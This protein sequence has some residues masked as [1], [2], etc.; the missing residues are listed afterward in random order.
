M[1]S[2]YDDREDD[3]LFALTE[4]PTQTD[5]FIQPKTLN[6]LSVHKR[7]EVFNNDQF[8]SCSLSFLER[9]MKIKEVG[10]G[11]DWHACLFG[12]L[13][14]RETD[15]LSFHFVC[16]VFWIGFSEP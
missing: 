3:I 7:H 11:Y 14:N 10:F 6:S 16:L 13:Y 2:K 1:D 5:I 8:L 15:R 4:D 12:V 9:S